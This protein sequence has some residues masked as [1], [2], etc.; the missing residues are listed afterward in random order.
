VVLSHR[1]VQSCCYVVVP[2]SLMNPPLL[3]LAG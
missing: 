2:L 3:E 1:H